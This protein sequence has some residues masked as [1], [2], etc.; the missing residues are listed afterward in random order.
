[1]Y[2]LDIPLR[3]VSSL[4]VTSLR[5]WYRIYGFDYS[6]GTLLVI[7]HLGVSFDDVTR[8][9]NVRMTVCCQFPVNDTVILFLDRR[10]LLEVMRQRHVNGGVGCP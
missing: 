4:Y 3:D 7:F 1:M 2:D 10:H 6:Y 8:S 5:P 9:S